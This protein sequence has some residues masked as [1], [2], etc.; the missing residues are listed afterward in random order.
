MRFSKIAAYKAQQLLLQ[1]SESS[2][3][4]EPKPDDLDPRPE[5]LCFRGQTQALVRHFFEL[6]CQVG[7][8]PSLLGREFFRARVS[9][10]A[11]PSF[12]EQVV[13]AR[14]VELCLSRLNDKQ[15]EIITLVGLYDFTHEEVAQMLHRSKAAISR[16]F[17]E[18]LD[19]LA[20]RFLEAGLLL[21][22]RPDRRQRQLAASHL[23]ADI[24]RSRKKSP[25]SVRG[26]P[27]AQA[28][29]RAAGRN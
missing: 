4:P 26:M 8:L 13:F 21:E 10:H 18:A 1:Y 19:A 16:W 25:Q 12:E 5:M 17:S 28:S 15:A 22:S 2:P 11:I 3:E 29:L 14:D 9:H 23:P 7:R 24:V 6:S 20:E 27:I